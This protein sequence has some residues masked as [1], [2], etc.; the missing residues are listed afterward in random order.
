MRRRKM[1]TV[2]IERLRL[3]LINGLIDEYAE[4]LEAMGD[5]ELLDL[6]KEKVVK[7]VKVNGEWTHGN[8]L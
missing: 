3:A 6:Y 1:G 2:T 5:E 4:A 7:L 8:A